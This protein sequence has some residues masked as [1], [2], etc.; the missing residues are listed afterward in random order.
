MYKRTDNLGVIG[1]SNVDFAGCAHSQRSTTNYVS[2]LTSGALSCRSCKQTITTSST[3]YAEFIACYEAVGQA[4][5]IENFITTLR[6]VDSI[7]KPLTL[8]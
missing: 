1:Y 7:S 4:M 5:W 6:V 8:Y 3:M 2:T